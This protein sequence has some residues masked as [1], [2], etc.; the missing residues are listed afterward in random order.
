M[1]DGA[2]LVTFTGEYDLASH[3]QWRSAL[4]KLYAEPSVIIDLQH[5][6]Y[7]DV[8]CVLELLTLHELRAAN[9]FERETVILGHPIVRRL[10]DLLKLRGLFRVVDSYD[11]AA[12]AAVPCRC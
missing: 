5:V 11:D 3:A 8:S 10:F 12:R 7:L 9:G 1:T 2:A 6:E 4:E